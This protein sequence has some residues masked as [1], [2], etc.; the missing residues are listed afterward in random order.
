M[1]SPT[2]LPERSR[3]VL[4]V[5]SYNIHH[6]APMNAY[7]GR[8]GPVRR[9]VQATD[10]D[11]V[12]LQEVDRR[13]VRSF[14]RHQAAAL[15]GSLGYVPLFAP[16]RPLLGGWYGHAVLSRMPPRPYRI[17]PLPV[18]PGREPRGAILFGYRHPAVG[19]IS[20][21]C[22][23]LQ[24]VPAAE[25]R[26]SE[27]Q[28]QLRVLLESLRSWPEPHLVMGDMNLR[29]EMAVPIFTEGGYEPVTLGATYPSSN[30]RFQI[31]WVATRGLRAAD[32][33]VVR[34]AASD[35]CP[36]VADLQRD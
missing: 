22:A 25:R 2:D 36:I 14:G 19:R 28:A 4:R 34:S 8:L 16:M 32:A 17:V 7:L 12:A 24:M 23:H 11:V 21:A 18:G 1:I 5:L 6:A 13:V 30:P 33:W 31:D 15:A 27:A 20:V 29:A 26:R 3:D 10:A 35:H 9:V